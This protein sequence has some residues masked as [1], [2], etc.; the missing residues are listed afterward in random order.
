MGRWYCAA[1]DGPR[2]CGA[3]AP[4]AGNHLGEATLCT[5]RNWPVLQ[6]GRERAAEQEA[7]LRKRL[8]A[9]EAQMREWLGATCFTSS[10]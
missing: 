3:T 5:Q 4:G 6:S 2:L 1:H 7:A 10:P 9:L 8:P